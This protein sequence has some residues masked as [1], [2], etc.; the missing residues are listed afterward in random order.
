M[1]TIPMSMGYPPSK[2]LQE[3]PVYIGQQPQARSNTP[4]IL[5]I[6]LVGMCAFGGIGV[7]VA[8]LLPA[9]QSAREAARRMQCS[10]NLKQIALAMHNYYDAHQCLPAG[11]IADADGK[12]MHSWRVALLP[13]L[14]Q[15]G[16]YEAYNFDE[17]WDSPH[18]MQI[19]SRM[20]AAYRCPSAPHQG[21]G[22][23]LTNYVVILSKTPEG[24]QSPASLFGENRWTQFGQV[25]DG[26]S[27]TLL[28]AEVSEPVMWTQPDADLQFDQMGFQINGLMSIGS[29][30]PGGANVAF[31]DGSVR[32]LSDSLDEDTLRLLIQPADGMPVMIP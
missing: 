25:T 22:S 9:V 3:E 26:T 13:Y 14:E 1:I 11:Y 10:N 7:L 6:V 29:Y 12:P 32:F 15:Q 8:L 4:L 31:A 28:V 17:P 5:T 23:M 16:L 21:P 18:N 20:P 2:P 19:A 24:N 30:H 27:N